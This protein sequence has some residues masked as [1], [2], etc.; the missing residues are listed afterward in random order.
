MMRRSLRLAFSSCSW[1]D[2]CWSVTGSKDSASFK[3]FKS[4]C[5]SDTSGSIR[6]GEGERQVERYFD[7]W[8]VGRPGKEKPAPG[9]A[10]S[11]KFKVD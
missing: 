4:S 1:S 3:G 8:D 9:P 7:S 2:P 11:R 10:S 5:T 6:E